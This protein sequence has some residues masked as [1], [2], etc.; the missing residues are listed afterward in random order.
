MKM[1]RHEFEKDNRQEIEDKVGQ[2]KHKTKEDES[3]E[4]GNRD[5]IQSSEHRYRDKTRNKDK[6]KGPSRENQDKDQSRKNKTAVK[7]ESRQSEAVIR[8]QDYNY[9]DD[10]IDVHDKIHYQHDL[11]SSGLNCLS[12]DFFIFK[13][14]SFYPSQMEWMSEWSK[15]MNVVKWKGINFHV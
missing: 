13:N 7:S 6:G 9:Q 3:R 5:K 14:Y 8:V 11:H 2:E 10:R 12:I 1:E 15:L 4:H